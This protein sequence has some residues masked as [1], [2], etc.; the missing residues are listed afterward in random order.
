MRHFWGKA[1]NIHFL[2][3]FYVLN[4]TRGV[5]QRNFS[6][7]H[8]FTFPETCNSLEVSVSTAL[9][10]PNLLLLELLITFREFTMAAFF[11]S[12]TRLF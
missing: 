5:T 1:V 7:P 10:I 4:L 11:Y 8:T 9:F 3:D 2:V 12:K 6:M